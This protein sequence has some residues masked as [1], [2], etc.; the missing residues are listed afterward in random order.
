M[1]KFWTLPGPTLNKLTFDGKVGY[2]WEVPSA[3]D[4]QQYIIGAWHWFALMNV[5]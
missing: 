3:M 2:G 4:A 1:M 5:P